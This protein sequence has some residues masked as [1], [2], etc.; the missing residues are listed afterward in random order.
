MLSKRLPYFPYQTKRAVNPTIS[1]KPKMFKGIDA[2]RAPTLVQG[3]EPSTLAIRDI[4]E[5]IRRVG[6]PSIIQEL[7]PTPGEH[8]VLRNEH[9]GDLIRKGV[10]LTG[11]PFHR[12]CDSAAQAEP[13]KLSC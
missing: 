2:K 11:T 7:K 3:K 10:L 5:E 9:L 8:P 6:T 1:S 12:N 13:E 4:R